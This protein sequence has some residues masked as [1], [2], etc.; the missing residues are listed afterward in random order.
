MAERERA[1]LRIELESKLH[2]VAEEEGGRRRKMAAAPAALAQVGRA[3]VHRGPAVA[4]PD[5]APDAASTCLE[6]CANRPC[7]PLTCPPSYRPACPLP[8]CPLARLQQHARAEELAVQLAQVTSRYEAVKELL[9]VERKRKTGARDEALAGQLVA[10]NAKSQ[11]ALGEL[12]AERTRSAG[13]AAQ[14][15]EANTLCQS[16][17]AEL[18]ATKKELAELQTRNAALEVRGPCCC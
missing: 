3:R 12:A 18:E 13:Q 1:V 4:M 9:E 14:L 15:A 5:P 7:V 10:A 11:S 8:P 6:L 17:K 2:E 16:L